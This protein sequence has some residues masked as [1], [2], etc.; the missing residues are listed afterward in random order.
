MHAVHLL[1]HLQSVE[2]W[3]DLF[4]SR[5]LVW[6]S[7][8][9]DVDDSLQVMVNEFGYERASILLGNLKRVHC[10]CVYVCVSVYVCVCQCKY[11]TLYV[12]VCM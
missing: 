5:P 11:M 2:N 6:V 1:G 10:E 8:P 4:K 9:A 3:L 12:R 7:V